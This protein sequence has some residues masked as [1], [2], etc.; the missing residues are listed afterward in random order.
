MRAELKHMQQSLGSTTIYVAYDQIEAMTLAHRVGILEKGIL[1]QFDTPATI[2]DDPANLFVAQ[3]IGSPP[4]HMVKGA[5]EGG[6]FQ[7]TGA[8]IKTPVSGRIA[9][10]VL[11]VRPEDC[12][13]A[14]PAKPASAAR[15]RH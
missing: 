5:P 9:A 3:F 6:E 11:R 2:Y 12:S 14:E 7:A 10:A 15:L 4:M 8:K 1:Q 13:I